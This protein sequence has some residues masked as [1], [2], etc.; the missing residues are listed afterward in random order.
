MSI[1]EGHRLKFK[2]DH[3]PLLAP[4]RHQLSF[5]DIQ[6]L[7]VSNFGHSR[8]RQALFLH[9]EE[10]VQRYLRLQLPCEIW[11]D[12][13][14][15]TEKPDPS[16]V[17]VLVQLDADVAERLT[18]EQ[19]L[20]IDE[21]NDGV[22]LPHVDSFVDTIYPRGHLLREGLD[23]GD[24]TW[25]EQFGLENSDRYLKGIAVIALWETDV[26]LRLRR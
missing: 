17:D 19:R 16:D 12:G 14:F 11:I 25:A 13:S 22:F 10:F 7:C 21:T 20:L 5:A 23:D 8:H 15:M 1:R 9:L 6:T 18:A 4:G 3:M 26:G 24:R 2:F